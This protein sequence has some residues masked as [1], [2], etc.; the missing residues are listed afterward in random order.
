MA[1]PAPRVSV[2]VGST[3]DADQIVSCRQVLERLG[4]TH[5]A[6]VLSA[7]RTPQELVSYV[8]SL[9]ERGVEIVIAAAGMAAHLAGVAAR[10][11]GWTDRH[12]IGRSV[13]PRC[14]ECRAS[15]CPQPGTTHGGRLAFDRRIRTSRRERPWSESRSL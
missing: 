9:E 13:R 1:S 10:A 6:R 4:I 5:E 2:I 11:A 7:H 15:R 14:G 8:A 3:S 12:R